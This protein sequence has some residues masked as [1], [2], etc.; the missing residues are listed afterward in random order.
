MNKKCTVGFLTVIAAVSLICAVGCK[1]DT[2]NDGFNSYN[3]HDVTGLVVVNGSSLKKKVGDNWISVEIKNREAFAEEVEVEPAAVQEQPEVPEYEYIEHTR[4]F[5]PSELPVVGEVKAR[6]VRMEGEGRAAKAVKPTKYVPGEIHVFSDSDPQFIGRARTAEMVYEGVYCYIWTFKD[7]PEDSKM[8]EEEIKTFADAFDKIYLKETALCGET[9]KGEVNSELYNVITP[10]EKVSLVLYD[11]GSDKNGFFY[12]YF[13]SSMYYTNQSGEN[14][15]E[16]IFVD[17]YCAKQEKLLPA[18]I[19]AVA[20]E[21]N[22][23]LN[24][25][26]K[27]LKYGLGC[28]SWYTEMLSMVTE[29]FLMEDLNVD[30][31][32]SPQTR[33][34]NFING[35]YN[36]GFKNWYF[37]DQFI[38]RGNYANAYAFGA[39]LARN[40]GGAALIHEIATNEFVNEESVVKAV[41]KINGTNLSF[42]DL[43]KQFSAILFNVDNDNTDLPSLNKDWTGKITGSDGLEYD[44][45]LAKIHPSIFSELVSEPLVI[46]FYDINKLSDV[47]L[48]SYGF[49]AFKFDKKTDLNLKLRDF[50]FYTVY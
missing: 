49:L 19:S 17:S 16:A 31:N 4:P 20:H 33:L 1:K 27:T 32:N 8:S 5:I 38:T 39:F 26:Q 43:I 6:E 3:L 48:E 34:I 30:L 45:S 25:V 29:D 42:D 10:D 14:A 37:N 46:K 11:I 23:L 18:L 28:E 7:E 22:H 40:Y 47:D 15:M 13:S 12:G 44:F 41:N 9:F 24:Y 2:E 21:F 50:L 35:S 36:Y